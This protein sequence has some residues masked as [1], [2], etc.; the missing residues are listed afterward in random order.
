MNW[1]N[2]VYELHIDYLEKCKET[3]SLQYYEYVKFD[4]EKM[5]I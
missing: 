2:K 3:I 5:W 4:M 1:R